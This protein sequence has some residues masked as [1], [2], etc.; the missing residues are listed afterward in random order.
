MDHQL[1]KNAAFQTTRWTLI[2]RAK[3]PAAP[4]ALLALEQL[5]CRYWYPLY[6]YAR[7]RGNSIEDAQDLT[8]DFF[9]KILEKNYLN[10]AEQKQGK[11]RW[12]LLTAFKCF[13]AN[14]YDRKRAAKR[15]GGLQPISLDISQ[16]ENQYQK[17]PGVD[18]APDKVFDR[19]WAI[20]VLKN[21]ESQLRNLYEDEGKSQRFSSLQ[22]YLPGQAPGRSYAE[23]ALELGITEAAVKMEVMRMRHRFGEILKAEIAETVVGEA[24]IEEEIRYLIEVVTY[25]H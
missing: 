13:L 11:F 18:A 19:R 25:S 7:S 16:A 4:E 6:A 1:N 12:F 23:T 5:C 15:G 24:Q 2:L 22:I 10:V 20:T 17:E 8:Q 9:A 14:E 3:D 21:A